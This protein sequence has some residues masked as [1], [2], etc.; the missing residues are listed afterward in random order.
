MTMNTLA[1]E[2][3]ATTLPALELSGLGAGAHTPTN[4]EL[5]TQLFGTAETRAADT[6]VA[7]Q[8]GPPE[9][10]PI[11]L[12][13]EGLV[14]SIVVDAVRLRQEAQMEGMPTPVFAIV[15]GQPYGETR[16][17][18]LDTVADFARTGEIPPAYGDTTSYSFGSLLPRSAEAG[19]TPKLYLPSEV[20]E[21]PETHALLEKLGFD[22][23]KVLA[24]GHN[25]GGVMKDLA[26]PVLERGQQVARIAEAEAEKEALAAGKDQ[27]EYSWRERMHIRRIIED[28]IPNRQ[29]RIAELD[30]QI[31]ARL[32]LEDEKIATIIAKESGDD[33][34]DGLIAMMPG[35]T[36]AGSQIARTKFTDNWKDVDGLS[37]AIPREDRKWDEATAQAVWRCTEYFAGRSIPKKLLVQLG[38]GQLVGRQLNEIATPG[39]LVDGRG[40]ITDWVQNPGDKPVGVLM[41]ATRGAEIID[42]SKITAARWGKGI[43]RLFG[44]KRL[45]I[46]DAGSVT[47]TNPETGKRETRGN[48][49]MSTLPTDGSVEATGPRNGVGPVTG[50]IVVHR[51]IEAARHKFFAK[52]AA[53]REARTNAGEPEPWRMSVELAGTHA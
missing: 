8:F 45:I 17:H 37:T 46:V 4:D 20:A 34:T 53:A 52:N 33:R 43:M 18:L 21:H 13:S 39:T 32:A 12:T 48:L 31:D 5:N 40:P 2:A 50:A 36:P 14:N 23:A 35:Y 10:G 15:A 27:S 42:A 28:E 3:P 51:V 22:P 19:I 16:E 7:E 29:E 30:R 1:A 44:R 38:L 25:L 24:T 49:D 11:I 41:S 47:V 26:F 6:S 9:R